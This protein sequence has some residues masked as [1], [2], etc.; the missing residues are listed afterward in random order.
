[1][2]ENQIQAMKANTEEEKKSL[3]SILARGAANNGPVY[4]ECH[5][6]WFYIGSRCP[7]K[8]CNE[9]KKDGGNKKV[10]KLYARANE[11]GHYEQGKKLGLE[12]EALRNFAHWGYELEFDVEV[13]LE[14]GNTTLLKV[15]GRQ[16][17]EK[18]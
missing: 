1:M 3:R 12:G 5:C 4:K 6:G 10:V 13:D 11:D 8:T 9:W 15:D 16:I 7:D 17:A 14:T 18:K 2:P